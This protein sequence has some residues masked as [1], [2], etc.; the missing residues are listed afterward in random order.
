M[1]IEV[2]SALF[3][4]FGTPADNLIFTSFM[5]TLI[6]SFIIWVP[7]VLDFRMA[8][9][10]VMC[11]ETK[12]R[13]S[14]I[15]HDPMGFESVA[16]FLKL[17]F[18]AENA[19]FYQRVE[20]YRLPQNRGVGAAEYLFETFIASNSPYQVNLS[21][22]TVDA[23]AAKLH[24][25]DTK[26]SIAALFIKP[27][28]LRS[29][30]AMTSV[31]GLRSSDSSTLAPEDLTSLFDVA[32][33]EV[34]R[35]MEKDSWVRYLQSPQFAVYARDY[36]RNAHEFVDTVEKNILA[37]PLSTASTASNPSSRCSET[38]IAEK[39]N[40][41]EL[42]TRRSREPEFMDRLSKGSTGEKLRSSTIEKS[43][44]STLTA[45]EPSHVPLSLSE[46]NPP[47]DEL[48]GVPLQD[49]REVDIAIIINSHA[50]PSTT[51][52]DPKAYAEL[53]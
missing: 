40:R 37:Q 22:T 28:Q 36:V 4:Y 10:H 21:A 26:Q 13:L 14:T 53:V 11:S 20:E 15:L 29:T 16:S 47:V 24:R 52:G 8:H 27:S 42:D 12:F 7:I 31:V 19:Y 50:G 34:L 3:F 17:E 32:Q 38:K 33:T 6:A 23:I 35:L 51:F 44:T 18:S 39:E 48:N 25:T 46:S 43:R 49:V 30:L 41:V 2:L 45:A 1:I 5:V 9:R